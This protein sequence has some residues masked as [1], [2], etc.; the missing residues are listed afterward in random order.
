MPSGPANEQWRFVEQVGET[1]LGVR[2]AYFLGL[3]LPSAVRHLRT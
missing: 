1:V 3:V 2:L